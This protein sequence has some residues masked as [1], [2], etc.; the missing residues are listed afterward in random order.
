MKTCLFLALAVVVMGLSYP[1]VAQDNTAEATSAPPQSAAEYFSQSLL[2][3]P[4]EIALI[5]RALTGT[6]GGTEILND[7]TG[8]AIPTRRIIKVAGVVY[9][10]DADWIVWINGHKIMPGKLLPQI[11]DIRVQKDMVDL[12]WFDRGINGVIDISLRP[13]QT[14]DIVTG[15][16]LPG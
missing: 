14:Y 9:R 12:K 11:V 16:L 3:T 8:E 2:F 15:V 4:A 1:V 13:H 6:V 10:S 5:Q 7:T